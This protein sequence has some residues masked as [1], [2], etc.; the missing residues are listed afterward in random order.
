M[1]AAA[2]RLTLVLLTLAATPAARADTHG[3]GVPRGTRAV[4]ADADPDRYVS[5]RGLRDT[6]DFYKKELDRRGLAH[7]RIG[8]YRVRGVDVVR[9]VFEAGDLAAI[10]VYRVGGKTLISFVKRARS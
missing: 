10:H 7:R 6:I 1:S 4:D 3:H 8:P 9:F 5:G 2:I